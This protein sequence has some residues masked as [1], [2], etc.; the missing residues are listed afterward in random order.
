MRRSWITFA[1]AG[2]V[3]DSCSPPSARHCRGEGRDLGE[4]DLRLTRPDGAEL[5]PRIADEGVAE[6]RQV[7]DGSAD[8]AEGEH[9]AERGAMIVRRHREARP[10]GRYQVGIGARVR[11][12]LAK[13][14]YVNIAIPRGFG[15][16][17]ISGP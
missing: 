2:L 14:T 4:G 3:A 6:P 7:L 9:L 1:N 15:R 13:A 16:G 5:L 12:A 8:G 17:G 11:L 10:V